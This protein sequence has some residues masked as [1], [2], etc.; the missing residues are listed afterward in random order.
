MAHP[1][2]QL[3]LAL[4][5]SGLA[6][7]LVALQSRIN[8]GLAQELG[9]G[10]VAAALS[11]AGGLV[12]IC[13]VLAFSPRGRAGV[14]RVS[15]EVRAGRLPSW[16]L[17]GGVAGA[18]FVLCQGLIA[19]LTGVALFTVGIVAGQVT[20][21]L[22]MDRLGLG[23]GGRIDATPTRLLG[24]VLAVAAVV[25]SVAAGHFGGVLVLVLVPVLVGAG[26][27]AQSMVNGLVRAAAES[28][29]TATFANFV[30]G[31]AALVAVAVVSVAVT[32][33]PTHWP[34]SFWLYSGGLIG[35]VFIAV[36]AMLVRRAGVLLL[37]MSNVAGQLVAAVAFEAGFPLAGGLTP[38]L[39]VGTGIALVAVI[40][41]AFPSKPLGGARD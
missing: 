26:M 1:K 16:A 14:V 9:N 34:T 5:G 36:A 35:V 15:R 22:V 32:G 7:M 23:P 24:T 27:A 2:L 25:V 30:I 17:L 4:V 10:Y 20:G 41:A 11:F 21:G 8:G 12:V 3:A 39:L 13:V 6:G 40:V 31:T 29:V 19:P 28:A 37:S 38:A 33:W 18:A